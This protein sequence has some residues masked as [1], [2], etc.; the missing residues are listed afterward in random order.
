MTYKMIRCPF[1]LSARG[2]FKGD[3]KQQGAVPS[4]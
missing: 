1:E 4:R 2:F 3:T